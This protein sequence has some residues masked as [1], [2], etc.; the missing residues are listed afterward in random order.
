MEALLFPL[1]FLLA[2]GSPVPGPTP[3]PLPTNP[4]SRV[5]RNHAGTP[6]RALAFLSVT[7]TP[8]RNA[9]GPPSSYTTGA[10][11]TATRP[12]AA[13]AS[14]SQTSQ[15]QTL[16]GGGVPS[17]LLDWVAVVIVAG[18]VVALVSARS[19]YPRTPLAR[20]RI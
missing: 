9:P 16:F 10:D 17:Q 7:L 12:Q 6:S 1:L 5:A 15:E 14:A 8:A 13:A 20:G 4:Y 11:P 19:V 18:V 3:L 2:G